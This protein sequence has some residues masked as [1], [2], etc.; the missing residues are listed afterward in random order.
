MKK[1]K[2]LKVGEDLIV[3]PWGL[4]KIVS[5]EKKNGF[6]MINREADLTGY[7]IPYNHLN[8]NKLKIGKD[9]IIFLNARSW[10]K[11]ARK[12]LQHKY[13]EMID[14]R[15]KFCK[16]LKDRSSG[17][18]SLIKHTDFEDGMTNDVTEEVRTYI[19]QYKYSTISWLIKLYTD[20]LDDDC[21][22]SGILRII[23]KCVPRKNLYLFQSVIKDAMD[24][25][26]SGMQEAAIMIMETIRLKWCYD[27]IVKT[28]YPSN[29]V[30]DYALKIGSEIGNEL[31]LQK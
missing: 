18:K 6:L 1:F 30:R 11:Y 28:Y 31:F 20:S 27:L 26:Q 25:G 16:Y 2:D 3:H 13:I 14:T 7:C 17:F 9:Y 21:L 10:Y 15:K 23:G 29:C 8:S 12:E 22:K 19:K 24:S 5:I 4:V